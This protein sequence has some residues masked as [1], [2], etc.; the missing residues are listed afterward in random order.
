MRRLC[1]ILCFL[2]ASIEGTL[3]LRDHLQQAEKGDYVVTSQGKN[4]TLLHILEHRQG[5]MVIEEITVPER[6]SP[7]AGQWQAWISEGAPQ[8]TSWIIYAL[9]DKTGAMKDFYSLTQH[10]W[11]KSADKDNLFTKL[12]SLPF[13]KVP[14]HR[15]KR[16]GT[17]TAANPN[18]WWQPKMI[19][20]GKELNDVT[21]DAWW[22]QWPNDGSDLGGREIT[23][24]LL[25][26]GQR[27]PNYFP[28]WLQA[29][30]NIT[31]GQLR[32]IDSGKKLTSRFGDEFFK[33]RK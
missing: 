19:F 32:V 28:Y 23:I 24:Y 3:F 29:K 31:K 26:D 33:L 4:I 5:E 17:I 13:E 15:R 12:L 14:D 30:G 25:A 6:S 11:L 1:L 9:E 20:E 8:N 10:C 27:Y 22:T 18:P 21:F 16:R 2:T 7:S